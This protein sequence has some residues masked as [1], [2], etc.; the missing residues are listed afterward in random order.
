MKHPLEPRQVAEW[1]LAELKRDGLLYQETAVYRILE[2]FG[3]AFTYYN[4]N[5]NLAIDRKVLAAFRALTADT[6]VWERG[7][8]YWRPRVA[9]D[10]AGRQ[11][12]W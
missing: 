7:E 10:S 3:E 2:L 11:T 5:G 9:T 4:A 8:R 12:D 1:M 6:V